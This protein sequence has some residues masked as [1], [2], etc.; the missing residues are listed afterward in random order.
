[1]PIITKITRYGQITPFGNTVYT[2]G[3]EARVIKHIGCSSP[4]KVRADTEVDWQG[5][6][7]WKSQP[8]YGVALTKAKSF[9]QWVNSRRNMPQVVYSNSIDVQGF[10]APDA[11]MECIWDGAKNVWD[12]LDGDFEAACLGLVRCDGIYTFT[13]EREDEVSAWMYG[14]KAATRVAKSFF[15][16]KTRWDSLLHTH[17]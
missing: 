8:P 11:P 17:Q 10:H 16:S 6:L 5:P 14:V 7:H 9:R 3:R 13:A 1:M 15:D 4:S 12:F 2:N